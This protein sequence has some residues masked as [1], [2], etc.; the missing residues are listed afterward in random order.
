MPRRKQKPKKNNNNKKKIVFIAIIAGA[1]IL[2]SIPIALIISDSV[3]KGKLKNLDNY[4]TLAD[5]YSKNESFDRALD[6]LDKA[7][8]ENSKDPRID[9]IRKKILALKKQKEESDK[10]NQ[11]RMNESLLSSLDNKKKNSKSP[12]D[13]GALDN[14]PKKE[15]LTK[16]EKP[17]VENP[18]ET[19]SKADQAKK[20]MDNGK[21]YLDKNYNKEALGEFDKAEKLDTSLADADAYQAL[22]YYKMNDTKNAIE[23]SR[24]A[25]KKDPDNGVAHYTTG[26]LLYDKKMNE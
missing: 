1:V 13:I 19:A 20:L 14:T 4:L 12:A 24:D 23:K 8:L 2:L 18:A 7:Y 25:L 5:E 21:K 15:D 16:Q 6:Y 10:Q 17:K 11:Q 22:A 26:K 3:N 9:E